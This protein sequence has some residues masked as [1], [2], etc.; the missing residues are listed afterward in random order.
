MDGAIPAFL[1]EICQ[2]EVGF[3]AALLLSQNLERLTSNLGFREGQR[4]VQTAALPPRCT[5]T[6][7]V[8][9]LR[10]SFRVHPWDSLN[11]T[12]NP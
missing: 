5:R 3:Y 7:R 4:E 10:R 2:S 8:Q 1:K 12:L 9:G 6:S 11:P